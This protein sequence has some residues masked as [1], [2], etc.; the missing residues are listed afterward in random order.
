MSAPGGRVVIVDYGSGN[1]R[2]VERALAH[3]GARP[4]ISDDPAMVRRAQALVLPGVGAAADIMRG[5][6]ER[7]LVAPVLE[8][9]ESGKPFLG[10]CMGYQALFEGS[11]EHGW[12]PCLGVVRGA[13]RRLPAGLK[14]PHMGWNQ[15]CQRVAHPIFAGVPNE[16][17]FYF[18][19][20]Y[21]GDVVDPTLVAG[22]TEYGLRFP[23]VIAR[24]NLV[25]TQFHPEKSGAWGLRLYRNFLDLAGLGC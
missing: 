19:H 16:A 15:V 11:E 20:S 2:S 7:G 14:V 18:V 5:L 24:D 8:A 21:Y 9:I 3:A 13:V 12:Q 17:N 1:V 6:R 22:D 25:A 23:C 10:V 4:L